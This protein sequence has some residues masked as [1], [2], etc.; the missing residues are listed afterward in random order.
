M[1]LLAMKNILFYKGRSITTFVLTFISVIFFVVYVS[2]MDGFHNSILLNSLKIYTGAI[3]I[4]HKGYREKGGND[5]YIQN[6]SNIEK[7]LKNIEG[8]SGYAPRYETY[9]LL[10]SKEYSS[11]AMIAAIEPKKE[12][13]LSELASAK[14]EGVYLDVASKNCFYMGEGLFKKL[15][16]KLNAEVAFIGSASDNSFAADI[17]KVCGVFKTGLFDFDTTTA[18]V[19]K[20]YF[21]E[22]MYAKN[23]ASYIVVNVENIEDVEK[24][25]EKIL[26][27]LNDKTLES[28]TWKE[29]MKTMVQAMEVDS[30]FGYISLSLFFVVIFFVIMIYGFINISSRTKEFGILR[31]IG[32]QRSQLFVLLFY[33]IF[34]LSSLAVLLATPVAASICYYFSIHPVVIE[35]MADMYK[36]YGIVSDKIPFAFN[37]F[38]MSWNIAL[39][40]MLNFLSI[41]YPYF[42]VSSFKP[43]EALKDV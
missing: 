11:A 30:I 16:L 38:T 36:S 28:L 32:L 13:N 4:Y 8:I 33:E 27:A 35:G 41:L 6:I 15:K 29:L 42:Y 40:Y 1:F 24:V 25:N 18:F 22:L 21:D 3:E 5:Y 20:T 31:S 10:S 39:I 2:M 34:I 12:K 9:A 43:V 23:K 14:T 19:N 7:K 37:I 26:S 17:F